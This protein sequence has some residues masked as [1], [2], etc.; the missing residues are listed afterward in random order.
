MLKPVDFV[1]AGDQP[2]EDVGRCVESIEEVAFVCRESGRPPVLAECRFEE[3]AVEPLEGVVGFQSPRMV[4]LASSISTRSRRAVERAEVRD[5][6]RYCRWESSL[7][8]D[9]EWRWESNTVSVS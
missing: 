6:V 2:D 8:L 3:L 5:L 4:G 1:V 9:L 7:L